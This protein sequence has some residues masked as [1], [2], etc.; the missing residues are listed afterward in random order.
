M[1]SAEPSGEVV[2]SCWLDIFLKPPITS[3]ARRASRP[4]GRSRAE[5]RLRRAEAFACILLGQC[6]YGR[7]PLI[8]RG[9]RQGIA[10]MIVETA[11]AFAVEAPFVDFEVRAEQEGRRQFLDRVTYRLRGGVEPAVGHRMAA[12]AAARGKQFRGC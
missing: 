2:S 9:P 3:A 8:S 11:D 6:R 5:S 7:P 4:V 1:R 12:L 10:R